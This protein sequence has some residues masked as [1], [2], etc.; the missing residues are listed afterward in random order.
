M[1]LKDLV[2]NCGNI[3]EGKITKLR[4]WEHRGNYLG[5]WKNDQI[6]KIDVFIKADNKVSRFDIIGKR[7][8]VIIIG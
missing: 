8:E 4:V 2:K 3:Q 6:N 7:L 5:E 1:T